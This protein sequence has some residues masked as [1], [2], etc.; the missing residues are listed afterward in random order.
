MTKNRRI[1]QIFICI[2]TGLFM[3]IAMFAGSASADVV[4]DNGE[5]G[6]SPIGFWGV[7]AGENPY[8]AISRSLTTMTPGAT[9]T[10]EAPLLGDNF[11]YL[12]WTIWPSRCRAVPVDI[13]NGETLIDTVEVNHQENGGQWNLLGLYSFD[14]GTARVV[15]RSLSS[16]CSTCADAVSFVSAIPPEL[17]SIN[18]EGPQEV[19]ENATTQYNCRAYYT[20]GTNGLV[21]PDN[22]LVDC[23]PDIAQISSEGI[24]TTQDV[25]TDK[26]CQITMTYAEGGI[27]KTAAFDITIK[28]FAPPTEYYIDNRDPESSQ[29]GSW[30][31]SGASNPYGIDSVYGR[32]GATFTWYFSPLQTGVFEV[33]IW[34]TEW[35]SRSTNV[36]VDI[37]HAGGVERININQ[38]LSGSGGQWNTMGEYYFENGNTYSVT[39]IS[40]PYPSSTCADATRFTLFADPTFVIVPNFVGLTQEA[41]EEQIIAAGLT[42]GDIGQEISDSVPA[43]EV[44]AQTPEE[45]S[46]VLSG[47]PVQ[48]T[49]SLGSAPPPVTVIIDDGDPP[50]YASGSW[51]P[52]GGSDPYEADS[53]YS[54]DPG[55][56]YTYAA[57]L[58]GYYTVSLW[59]SS[60]SSRCEEVPVRV[61]DGD[62]L[63]IEQQINQRDGGGEWSDI[64]TF[65][66]DGAARVVVTS[67]SSDCTT[68]ADAVK[69]T[70]SAPLELD[71][72]EIEGPADVNANS[73]AQYQVMA[74]YTNG[75]TVGVQAN[76]WDVD[77]SYAGIST[78]GLLQAGE[79]AE[80]QEEPCKIT[81]T[82]T[83]GDTTEVATYNL[84]IR[85][86]LDATIDNDGDGTSFTGT[87]LISGGPNPF[88][89]GSL[90]SRDP[91][92]TYT[93]SFQGAGYLEVYLWWT[94]Y[95]SR[96]SNVPV[97]IYDGDLLLEVKEVDQRYNGGQWNL[98]GAYQF[99]VG[100]KVVVHSESTDCSTSADAA[101]FLQGPPS[102]DIYACFAYGPMNEVPRFTEFLEEIGAYLDGDIW[103]Y[104]NE[105]N[106][107]FRIH[108][109]HDMDTMRQALY[110]EDA[111]IL[112]QGHSNYGLGPIFATD[113]EVKDQLI[114][115]IRYIDDDRILNYSSPWI[116]VNVG[117]M[118]TGQSYPYWWPVYKD[119]TSGIMPY[120]FGDPTGELPPYNYYMTYQVSGDS[121][122]YKVETVRGG[123]VERFPDSNV[124]A[125]YSPDGSPPDPN[126]PEHLQ[127]YITNPTPKTYSCE[128]VGT[129]TEA[130]DLEGHFKE[131]YR[132]APAGYGAK[133]VVW[134]LTIPF[135]GTYKVYTW[136]P[137]SSSNAPNAPYTVYH[138]GG[139][140]TVTMDQR[141][142]GGQWNEIG[143]FSFDA[144]E[145]SV[146]LTDDVNTGRVIADAIRVAHADN[147]PE[148]IQ[149]DFNVPKRFGT[150]PFVAEFDSESTGNISG[151]LWDFG[152]GLTNNTRSS[153]DHG[154]NSPGT[155]TV[156][157]T[158]QGEFGS[159]TKVKEAYITVGETMPETFLYAEF[160]GS[161][162][163]GIVPTE[164]SF[165]DLSFGDIV[166]WAWD[167]GDG[168]TSTEKNPSHTYET[169]GNYTVT[170]T[171]TDVNGDSATEVKEKFV[172]ASLFDMQI[173]NVDYPKTHFRSKT[174][175]KRKELEIDRSK[176]KYSRMFLLSCNTGNYY[177]HT[178]NHG[179]YFYDLS[180]TWMG[181]VPGWT[182]YLR[183]YFA[184][185]SDEDIWE[186]LQSYDPVY[187][188]YDF[189]KYPWD[190]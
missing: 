101:H 141:F 38:Q 161:G 116:H 102:E 63:L 129:W 90:Y 77:T 143:E 36:P 4:I 83:E 35:P 105:Q 56:E 14:S 93:Y 72:I 10:F 39:V 9:Y 18:I 184:G 92:A 34:W 166:S 178:F 164:A 162:Q 73:E 137:Q 33:S 57:T 75:T 3:L 11:V 156:S 15:I 27:T 127:Y 159:S 119:G 134:T 126:N 177:M 2:S 106:K 121:T 171:V 123:A 23:N 163:T 131:N 17:E 40:Q 94:S 145:Y 1:R 55:A 91:N 179:I 144:G 112:L 147:P 50:T 182:E 133:Q 140:S 109:V 149:A 128:Y 74:Y 165:D 20:N 25:D 124:P 172:L 167:F 66:F 47:S 84:T 78:D 46:E 79:L 49:V 67:L 130:M 87:W 174:I 168:E 142:N 69:F 44:M 180:T 13:Y 155:Y 89:D 120:D 100:P 108:F 146:V 113:Q 173:D 7:S 136:W 153:I 51:L 110:T 115:D 31:V 111:H 176:L 58:H 98:I 62:N 6:T 99:A 138:A 95:S 64:G 86:H 68:C 160:K 190:Q 122:Y 65:L 107:T 118:R 170:L 103:I 157:L 61:F 19:N 12:W 16:S 185:K 54:K 43:E 70:P 135:A 60:Y 71:R 97:S 48:L 117:G 181:V 188:Y 5:P 80:G 132:Y 125:W 81:V 32:D 104:R 29:T 158:V 24:L 42:V 183:A 187:D 26:P 88:G 8:G 175:L 96:C 53:L 114:E 148:V 45:G 82:Y 152:D 186:I 21:G 151:Y 22:C 139:S 52:S 189:N 85:S 59:W 28:D 154:Y 150:V 30:S 169:P 37:E 41:A 76:S